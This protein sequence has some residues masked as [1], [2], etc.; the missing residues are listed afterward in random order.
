MAQFS[1]LQTVLAVCI[2]LSLSGGVNA[3]LV[4]DRTAIDGSFGQ[5]SVLEGNVIAYGLQPF[6]VTAGLASAAGIEYNAA[7][8]ARPI[9]LF[10][11][12]FGL[13]VRTW[14]AGFIFISNLED[15]LN[16]TPTAS[17]EFSVLEATAPSGQQFQELI[18][19][20]A[21][22]NGETHH[23]FTAVVDLGLS[24]IHI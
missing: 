24:L 4:F 9:L 11:D 22:P 2:L 10:D 16:G 15:A 18:I 23:T 17:F 5:S 21:G 12:T 6:P 14:D 20:Q 19:Q 1:N 13:D 8:S 3:Q 7:F